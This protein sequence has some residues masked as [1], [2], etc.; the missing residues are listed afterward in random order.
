MTEVDD[1]ETGMAVAADANREILEEFRRIALSLPMYEVSIREVRDEAIAQGVEFIPGN[2]M[3]SV[4]KTS[5]WEWSGKFVA[6]NHVKSH[7]HMVRSWIRR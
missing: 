1:K 2:W 6:T 7:C 4:F 3:G 5:D